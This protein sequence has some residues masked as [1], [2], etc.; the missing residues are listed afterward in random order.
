MTMHH[1]VREDDFFD[2]CPYCKKEIMPNHVH[3]WHS[4][5]SGEKHYKSMICGCGKHLRIKVDFHG[6]GQDS[7]SRN[8]IKKKTIEDKVRGK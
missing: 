8:K 6:S 1:L 3:K 5:F 4:E 7:W 2:F